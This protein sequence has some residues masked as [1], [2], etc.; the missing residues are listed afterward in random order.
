VSEVSQTALC[1][2]KDWWEKTNLSIYPN[3][4]VIVTFTRRKEIKGLK[5]PTHFIKTIQLSIEDSTL[6]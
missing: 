4:T 1:T 2:V 5:E 6:E 3:K